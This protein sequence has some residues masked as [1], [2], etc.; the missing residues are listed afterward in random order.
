MINPQEQLNIE[1]QT[2]KEFINLKNQVNQSNSKKF[3]WTYRRQIEPEAKI[4][5]FSPL[6][7]TNVSSKAN[8]PSKE[9]AKSLR[10]KKQA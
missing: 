1:G 10:M 9:N 5:L 2:E 7:L 8:K 3:K 4:V 6:M